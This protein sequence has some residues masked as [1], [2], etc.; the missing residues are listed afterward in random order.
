MQNSVHVVFKGMDPNKDVEAEVR[1]WMVKLGSLTDAAGMIG[2][3]M[4]VES[5]ERTGAQ[6]HGGSRYV[7]AIELTTLDADVVVARDQSATRR[8]RTCTSRFVTRSA[9]CGAGWWPTTSGA[10]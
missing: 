3:C 5:I 9:S 2:G 7:G 6:R 4:V 8:T 1:A 10:C